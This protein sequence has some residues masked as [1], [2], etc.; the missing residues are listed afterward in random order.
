MNALEKLREGY[1]LDLIDLETFERFVGLVLEGRM[2]ALPVE[3]ASLGSSGP[4]SASTF[5]SVL[6]AGWTEDRLPKGHDWLD[7][8]GPVHSISLAQHHENRL[9]ALDVRLDKL[10]L[11]HDLR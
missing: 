1:A 4:V 8:K 7:G 9:A 6:K 11:I 5:A 10:R 3:V 2:V